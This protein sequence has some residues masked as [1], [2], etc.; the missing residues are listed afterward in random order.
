[1]KKLIFFALTASLLCFNYAC[2]KEENY[3]IEVKTAEEL[4]E[5]LEKVFQLSST[6]ALNQFF[7]EWNKSVSFNTAMSINEKEIYDIYKVF[8][9]PLSF[10]MKIGDKEYMQDSNSKYVVVQNKIEYA[11]IGKEHF[12]NLLAEPINLE[13]IDDFRPPLNLAKNRILYQMPE[14]KEALN[15]FLRT[16]S[17]DGQRKDDF[18][19]PYIPLMRFRSGSWIIGTLPLVSMIIMDDSRTSAKVYFIISHMGG[20]ATLKKQANKWIVIENRATT[21]ID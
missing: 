8:Y 17:T 21:H 10:S 15:M 1:M 20:V 6:N 2:N 3:P 5:N 14:Y 18:I 11:I 16:E 19:R 7:T 4:Y 9:N 12:D 13:T